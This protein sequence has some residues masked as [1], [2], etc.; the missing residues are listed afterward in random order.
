MSSLNKLD[1]SLE[2]I[3]KLST[4]TFINEDIFND[5]E[6]EDS[7]KNK[8]LIRKFRQDQLDKD[9]D[10]YWLKDPVKI[11][12]E[13]EEVIMLIDKSDFSIF[14]IPYNDFHN[15]FYVDYESNTAHVKEDLEYDDYFAWGGVDTYLQSY[16][17]NHARSNIRIGEESKYIVRNI[18][19]LGHI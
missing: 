8:H 4:D 7:Y 5:D 6:Y 10:N 12:N 14:F 9:L 3:I 16:W 11:D 13:N 19:L 17:L 2:E 18:F 1:L 15:I